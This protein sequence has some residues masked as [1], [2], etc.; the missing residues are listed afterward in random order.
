MADHQLQD[1]LV[2]GFLLDISGKELREQCEKRAAH[3][4]ERKAFYLEKIDKLLERKKE[5][6]HN[7]GDDPDPEDIEAAN[8]FSYSNQLTPAEETLRWSL[9]THVNQEARFKFYAAHINVERVYRFGS[10]E[11]RAF[12]FVP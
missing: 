3:H 5:A 7:L 12:D 6:S 1:A 9:R 8:K 10:D 4:S 2:R 11:L